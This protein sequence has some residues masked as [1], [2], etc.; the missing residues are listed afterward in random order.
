MNA[1]CLFVANKTALASMSF[2]EDIGLLQRSFPLAVI[3]VWMIE[4]QAEQ[5]R[6][7]A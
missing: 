5:R 2:E 1:R 6:E 3:C 7:N 4:N